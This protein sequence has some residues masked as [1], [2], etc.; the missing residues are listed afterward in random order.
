M[1][2]NYIINLKVSAQIFNILL[3]NLT[4]QI[5]PKIS[6]IYRTF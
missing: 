3:M 5:L 4:I 2:K 6:K 1:Y